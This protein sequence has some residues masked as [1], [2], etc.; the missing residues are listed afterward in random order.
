MYVG[1]DDTD[2]PAG[3]CTTYLCALILR[4]LEKKGYPFDTPR[5][6]RLNPNIPYKTRGNGAVSFRTEHSEEV[7]DIVV[8]F[9][10]RYSM[11]DPN[12][13]SGI[14]FLDAIARELEEFSLRCLHEVLEIEEGIETAERHGEYVGFGNKRGTIGALASCSMP[15]PEVTYE[16]LAYRKKENWGKRREINEKSVIE[17]DRKFFPKTFNNYDYLNKH[18]CIT[19][20]GVDPVL[21]GIRGDLSVLEEAYTMIRSEKPAFHQIFQTNQGTDMHLTKKKIGEVCEYESVIIEGFIAAHPKIFEG[22][23]VSFRLSDGLDPFKYISKDYNLKGP[24]NEIIC[25]AY[26]PTKQFKNVVRELMV[27]DCIA[28]WGAVKRTAFGLTLNLEKIEI[29]NL[30]KRYRVI[31][32]LCSCGKKMESIGMNKGYRC[33][34]CHTK[35]EGIWIEEFR[36]LGLGLYEVAVSARRHLSKPLARYFMEYKQAL[37][38]RH[39]LKLSKGKLAAQCAHGALEAAEAASNTHK[40]WYGKWRQEG[41]RKVVLEVE[42]EEEL[43]ELYMKTKKAKLP[44]SLIRD[45]GLT[46]IPPN[47][48]T[49]VAIGPAPEPLIDELCGKLKLL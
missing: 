41:Q 21:F 47:T 9:V 8:D 22:G 45:A 1:I 6:I 44:T 29:K 18:I 46:E 26:E 7:K 49:V 14:V 43:L 23:H 48:T 24:R 15:L 31:P 28:A 16:I 25:V 12:T 19:P 5:L 38:T 11:R 36:N 34:T 4:E 20:A 10:R 30:E 42:N 33:R 37:I 3:M 35:A 13:N 32:P 2:S 27:G 40:D 17:M 39:D